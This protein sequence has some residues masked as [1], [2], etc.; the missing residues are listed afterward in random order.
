MSKQ[1]LLISENGEKLD[2]PSIKRAEEIAKEKDLDLVCVNEEK[3]VYKLMDMSKNKYKYKKKQKQNVQK[4]KEVKFSVNIASHDKETKIK[5]IE[6]FLSKKCK[7]K[8]TIE[9]PKR[10]PLTNREIEEFLNEI[11]CE[12][13]SKFEKDSA[14]SFNGKITNMTIRPI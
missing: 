14:I 9:K 1:I 12:I 5:S 13:I 4:T 2:V 10:S 6:K 11:L 3:L 8:I 7:V